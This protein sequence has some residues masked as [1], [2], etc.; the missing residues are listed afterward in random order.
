MSAWYLAR[1]IGLLDLC[2]TCY[3]RV[4]WVKVEGITYKSPCSVVLRVEEDYPVFGHLKGIYIVNDNVTLHVRVTETI[5]F[6][7]HHHS[8]ILK[9]TKSFETVPVKKLYDPWPLH[10]R[11]L[12]VDG[13]MQQ[14]II[15]KHHILGTVM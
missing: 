7:E 4:N 10:C 11:K 13:K 3:H 5:T 15:L 2:I 14:M 6:D 8:Y 12:E 9:A 1:L